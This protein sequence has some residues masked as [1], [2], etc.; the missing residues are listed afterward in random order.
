MKLQEVF[1][2][3]TYGELSQ[4]SIGGGEAGVI[5]PANYN[6]VLAHVNLGLTALYK[7]FTLKQGRIQIQLDV[8]RAE[9]PLLS[10]YAVSSRT[11]REATGNRFIK[12]STAA[13]FKDDLLK[14][15]KVLG[16]SG[17]EYNLNMEDD[18]LSMMT[19]TASV[20]RVP[21]DILVPPND[22]PDAMKTTTLDVLYRANHPIIIPEGTDLD[23]ET[24]EL[25]LPYTHL[26]PLLLFVAARA[27]APIGM[28]QEAAA[29]NNFMQMYELACQEIDNKGLR[30]D[31]DSQAD[32]LTR[33]G[34]V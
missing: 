32:R 7:R 33:N 26:Q 24:I 21:Q 23:P 4:L 16:S 28:Q 13:P 2:Q 8:N 14:V 29:G 20:L 12:D 22:L 10:K 19:P 34:W 17:W 11:S 27:H 30:V 31:K 9:Y 18:K 5:D 1:D 25:E 6:R 3:L 15:E